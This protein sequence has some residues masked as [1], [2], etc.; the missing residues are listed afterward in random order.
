MATPAIRVEFRD[1]LK[2]AFACWSRPWLTIC[3]TR[4]VDAGM[5]NADAPPLIA[6]STMR[7]QV[8]ATPLSSTTAAAICDAPLRRSEVTM[9]RWRGSRSAQTPPARRKTRCASMYA[10]S[11]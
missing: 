4:P 11:T 9:T 8:C 1:R 7:C 10:E 3:G 5:K 2:R 6:P